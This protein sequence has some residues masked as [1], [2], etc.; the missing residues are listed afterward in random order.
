FGFVTAWF[1]NQQDPQPRERQ[2]FY[3]GS[4][5]IYAMWV[6]IG[7]VGVM[8][9][10]RA[11]K[12]K[13][14]NDEE[15]DVVPIGE[16][17]VGL[18][19]ATLL[20]A[21]VLVP[22]NQCVGLAGM[23][24]GKTFDEASKWREYSR[25]HDYIP[26]EYSYN[27][28]QSC[29]KDAILFTAGD[30]D[31][32]PLW[33][34][35]SAYGI[36]RDVR[37][38]NLSLGN[39]SWYIKQLKNDSWGVGKKMDLPGFTDKVLD[40]VDDSEFG[41]HPV[42]D[43]SQVVSVP[44]SAATMRAFTGNPNAKDTVMTWRYR[45]EMQLDQG[46]DDYYF[47]VAD[48]LVKSIVE[49]NINTRPIYFAPFVQDN[50][51][52]GLH[53]FLV[54]E[55]MAQRVTPVQQHGGGS[56]GPMNEALAAEG[57]FNVV[58]KDHLSKTPKRGYIIQTFSDPDARWSN[59]DRTN[60]SVFFSVQSAYYSL[61]E[62]FA[63]E[64]KIAEANKALDMMDK[65][66]PIERVHYEDRMIPLVSTLYKRL[67]NQ[68]KAKKYSKFALTDLE[69]SYNE[70]AGT[71]Q[72]GQRDAEVGERYAEALIA[73][74]D[75]D[76]AQAVLQHL[77]QAST[78]KQSQGLIMFR[79]EEVN[80]MM[81]EKKGDKKQAL[82]LYDQF[83]GKYGQAIAGSGAEFAAQFTELRNHVEDLR[84]ELNPGSAQKDSVKK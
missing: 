67:G 84:R 33:A 7:A 70:I 25:S 82:A 66:I 8:E 16:G 53:P 3:V 40:A 52:I 10:L 12:R 28:L 20:A 27:V 83:F 54:S 74:G 75:L 17:N 19:G 35:Q 65:L 71:A 43:K 30:N 61:A 6:G 76:K 14:E 32:F 59:E 44:V 2:Y 49:G 9:L 24:M 31:T 41:V 34:A 81:T 11:R 80:A 5:Y 1:Q 51:L 79:T 13:K 68:E 23:A 46:K 47:L 29:E 77:A 36:R 57:A 69:K 50:Y 42:R 58:D 4:F 38:V 64:G 56:L 73:A 55:G 78:D 72:L 63:D 22:L 37:I 21:V 26:L 60:Y 45:G 18:L 48:Q 15:D 39:M 62:Q